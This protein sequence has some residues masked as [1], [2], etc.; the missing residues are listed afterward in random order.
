MET[1]GIEEMSKE[2]LISALQVTSLE[3]EG[4]RKDAELYLERYNE[5]GKENDILKEKL[6][7]IRSFAKII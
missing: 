7:V 2:E 5:I 1:K 6:N 3:L 4:A